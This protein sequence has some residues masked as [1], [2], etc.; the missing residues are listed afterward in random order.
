[1][2][3]RGARKR[4]R[5]ALGPPR[6]APPAPPSAPPAPSAPPELIV[7]RCPRAGVGP[8]PG[9][10]VPC[11]GVPC[12]GPALPHPSRPVPASSSPQAPAA[13][14]AVHGGVRGSSFSRSLRPRPRPVSLVWKLFF[15]HLF[16]N[17]NLPSA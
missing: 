13:L 14:R 9:A 11:R 1:M 17:N 6:D 7:A 10:G 3:G 2:T 4:C 5:E 8:P 15:L 16:E 12:R